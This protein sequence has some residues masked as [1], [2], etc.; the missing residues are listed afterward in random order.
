LSSLPAYETAALF[1]YRSFGNGDGVVVRVPFK[2]KHEVV[3]REI[4]FDVMRTLLEHKGKEVAIILVTNDR[5]Y[6]KL[7]GECLS[8]DNVVHVVSDLEDYRELALSDSIDKM[9]Y[10]TID[11][12]RN[13]GIGISH[14]DSVTVSSRIDGADIEPNESMLRRVVQNAIPACR[15]AGACNG[16]PTIDNWIAHAQFCQLLY[17]MNP[18]V[19]S[20]SGRRDLVNGILA[21]LMRRKWITVAYIRGDMR[22]KAVFF[23]VATADE[24]SQNVDVNKQYY[25]F[26]SV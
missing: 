15:K 24:I 12:A 5:D 2:A 14:D 3:D 6:V 9:S 22:T 11:Q 4:I 21:E 23:R 17:G 1:L 13:I 26:S 7:L 18:T 25:N 16:R 19:T 10:S 20:P 8:N